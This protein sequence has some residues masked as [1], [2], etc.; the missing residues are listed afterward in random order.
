MYRRPSPASADRLRRGF[1]LIELMVV[2]AIAAVLAMVAYP[3]YQQYLVRGRIGEATTNLQDMRTVAERFFQDQRSYASVP[4]APAA[5]TPLFTFSCTSAATSYTIAATG[6]GTMAGFTYTIDQTDTRRSTALP[7]G[8]AG[9]ASSSTCW[10]RR[11]DG[12]C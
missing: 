7:T 4:C 9:A 11:K 1:T 12:T 3:G 10:V 6:A 2:V 5:T 8:W